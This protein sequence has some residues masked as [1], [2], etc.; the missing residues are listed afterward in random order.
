MLIDDTATPAATNPI[1]GAFT[2]LPQGGVISDSYGG[3]TYYFLVN[4]AGGDGNDLVL[5]SETAPSVTGLSPASGSPTGGTAVT[6][7]GTNLAAATAVKFGATAVTT[8]TSDTGTQIVL[9][10]PAG[11]AGTV[12]VTVV[13]PAGAS[14]ISPADQFAYVAV[15]ACRLAT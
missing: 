11:S 2:N 14:P 13:A 7:T 8:F 10:S 6:I 12:D 4:Y 15:P 3:T 9:N 1:T 5:T